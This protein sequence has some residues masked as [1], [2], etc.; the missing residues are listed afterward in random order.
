MGV[1]GYTEEDEDFHGSAGF[2]IL[3]AKVSSPSLVTGQT[4]THIVKGEK[5]LPPVVLSCLFM[6]HGVNVLLSYMHNQIKVKQ[7]KSDSISK[8]SLSDTIRP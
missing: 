1:L 6:H 5:Q 2:I 3:W 4:R 8:A 7:I